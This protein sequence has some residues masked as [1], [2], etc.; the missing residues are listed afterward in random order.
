MALD[1][2]PIEQSWKLCDMATQGKLKDKQ[3]SSVT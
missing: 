3:I 1:E 2:S